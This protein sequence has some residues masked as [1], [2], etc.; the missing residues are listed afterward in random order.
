MDYK[1]Y[2]NLINLEE[3]TLV[4]FKCKNNKEFKSIITKLKIIFKYGIH[5]R[6]VIN[7]TDVLKIARE[8]YN[9]DYEISKYNPKDIEIYSLD[10][11]FNKN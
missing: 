9:I 5:K 1:S 2:C 7:N 6:I 4:I 8:V 11:L 10:F 3:E